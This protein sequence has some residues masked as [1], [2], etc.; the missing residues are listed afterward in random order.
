MKREA[1][2]VSVVRTPVGKFRG[3][4]TTLKPDKLAAIVIKEAIKRAR[5]EPKTIDE[6]IFGNITALQYNNMARVASL[7]AGLPVEVPAITIDRQCGTSVNGLAYAAMF[8]ESGYHDCLVVGGVNSDTHR[9][10]IFEKPSQA[11]S[12]TPMKSIDFPVT[13]PKEFQETNMLV[14]AEN[15]AKKYNISREEADEFAVWSHQKAAKAWEMGLFDEHTLQVEVE[16]GKGKTIVVNKDETLRPETSKEILA[17]LPVV[18][19]VENG[20]VTAGNSSPYSDGASAMVVMEK[21]KAKELGLPILA[22][23]RGYAA[24]GVEPAIMG[25][26]PVPATKKL[27][28]QTGLTLDDID[29][30]ELNEAFASQALSVVKELEI[31]REKL[32]VNGG[33]IALGHPLAATGGILVAKMISELNRRKK[34]FGLITFC[35]AGGQGVSILLEREE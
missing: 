24:A 18:S 25:I 20:I 35:C 27:L 29:L 30:I 11:F 8:I 19:G 10:Y 7:E 22:T 5:I 14:T 17:K 26:G 9:V 21:R 33:A 28:K 3:G 23:F 31:D 2:I 15:L 1:V 32:N 6:V 16:V 12:M 13:S 4:Y 34:R